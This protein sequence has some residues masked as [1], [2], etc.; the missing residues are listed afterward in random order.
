VFTAILEEKVYGPFFITEPT[1]TW[2]IHRDMLQESLMQQLQEDK[3]NLIFYKTEPHCVSIMKWG[4]TWT[5]SFIIN[6][7]CMECL[8]N[9]SSHVLSLWILFGKGIFVKDEFYNP[10][11]PTIH[12]RGVCRSWA[13]FSCKSVCVCVSRGRISIWQCISHSRCWQLT[14]LTLRKAFSL[15]FKTTLIL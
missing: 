12:Q 7:F 9:A 1:V 14:L 11:P 13:K 4:Y 15:N 3:K 6:E 8:W 5:K 10:I 2:R